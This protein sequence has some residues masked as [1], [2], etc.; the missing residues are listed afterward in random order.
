MS[1]GYRCGQTRY[2]LAMRMLP[3]IFAIA[4]SLAASEPTPA[5]PL[6]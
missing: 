5:Y 1:L 3:L 2:N 4:G 6:V